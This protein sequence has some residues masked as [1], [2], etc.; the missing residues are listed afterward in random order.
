MRRPDAWRPCT[1]AR[2]AVVVLTAAA[3]AAGY[4]ESEGEGPPPAAAYYCDYRCGGGGAGNSGPYGNPRP[5]TRPGICLEPERVYS[6]QNS[7]WLT[8]ETRDPARRFPFN[9]YPTWV[10]TA[11]GDMTW[12]TWIRLPSR[13]TEENM[14]LGTFGA[15]HDSN[16]FTIQSRR[17]YGAVLIDRDSKL[18]LRTNVGYSSGSV[19]GPAHIDVA[20]GK[21]HHVA[22]VFRQTGGARILVKLKCENFIYERMYAAAI[23]VPA[24]DT[25]LKWFIASAMGEAADVDPYG[26]TVEYNDGKDAS[27]YGAIEIKWIDIHAKINVAPHA[28][29][30]AIGLLSTS[31]LYKVEQAILDYTV[32][33]AVKYPNRLP[34]VIEGPPERED[35]PLNATLADVP[36]LTREAGSAFL[37]VDG[38][39][40]DGWLTYLPP[41]VPREDNIAMDGNLQV[42]GGL[43]GRPLDAQISRFRLWSRGL[44]DALLAAVRGCTWP[45]SLSALLGGAYPHN[46]EADY[47]LR[48]HVAN[49]VTGT[50]DAVSGTGIIDLVQVRGAFEVGGVCGPY[51]SC[52]Y[53]SVDKCPLARQVPFVSLKRCVEFSEWT[54]CTLAGQGRGL[55]VHSS[56]QGCHAGAVG[57]GAASP[58]SLPS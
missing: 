12:E 38:Y 42:G 21:W 56:R 53:W 27:L 31:V 32:A 44:D 29:E 8:L 20:D 37:V 46:L 26:I 2:W 54:F 34:R 36:R 6:T 9:F 7:G 17:R 40:G 1:H 52:P 58:L 51:G 25:E 55:P 18:A 33:M 43:L 41:N 4:G 45:A 57:L 10:A 22:A 5:P 19:R 24:L 28:A 15:N 35:L 23:G 50:R 3:R 30:T 11:A 48:G 16:L 49:S 47:S 14:L 13:P 39:H